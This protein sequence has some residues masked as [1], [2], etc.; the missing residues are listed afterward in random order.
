[1]TRNVCINSMFLTL[2]NQQM[3]FPKH[4]I[5]NQILKR[6][7][8]SRC[9]LRSPSWKFAKPLLPGK[10]SIRNVYFRVAC[11]QYC[12]N[13]SPFI[14]FLTRRTSSLVRPAC[15]WQ[16]M[17]RFSRDRS[18]FWESLKHLVWKILLTRSWHAY[19]KQ[20]LV[21]YNKEFHR[22][23]DESIALSIC[24]ISKVCNRRLHPSFST[25]IRKG[26][27]SFT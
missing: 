4:S 20:L 7:S 10:T 19:Q 9:R 21:C 8:Y 2:W 24:V 27:L 6:R 22:M 13:I 23:W 17:S 1:M 12:S 26:N 5:L 11:V 18:F 3:I 16:G 15:L 14:L 25:V